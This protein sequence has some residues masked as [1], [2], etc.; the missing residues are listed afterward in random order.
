MG[1]LHFLFISAFLAGGVVL[2]GQT[3]VTGTG[4]VV[5]QNQPFQRPQVCETCHQRQYNELR[6]AVKAG[7]RNAS[8]LQNALELSANFL[9][10]GLLRPVYSDSTILLPDGTPLNTN[11][12]TT[13]LFGEV[14][15][16]QSGFCLTCHNPYTEN[17]LNPREVPQLAGVGTQFQPETIRPLR[18]YHM[19]DAQGNQ[20]L[21]ADF[22][23]APPAGSL[24]SL[25]A[26]GITCDL[27]HNVGGPDLN[28][29]FQHDGF[30]NMS[31]LLNESM[32]KVGPFAFPV[33]PKNGFHM[34]SNDQSKISYLTAG[35]FCNA[36]HDVRV[37]LA[38]QG[39]GDLQAEE[40][41]INPGG[42]GVAYFRLEN[43]STEWQTGAYNST[44]NPFG[45][46]TRCQ[47]CHMSLFPFAGSST[48]QVGDMTVTSPTPAIFPQN[49]A[50]VPATS[51]DQNYPLSLRKVVT[52]YFT[53]VDVPLLA[54]SELQ[55][56]LGSSFP[57]PNGPGVD[58]YG[59]PLSLDARRQALLGA[60]VRLNLDQTDSTAAVGGV[61]TVR[62]AVVAL[63]GHRFP[64]GFSQERT[65]YIQLSVTDDNG[66]LLYQSG[67]VV[68]KPHPETGETRPDGNLND[69]DLEHAHAVVNPGFHAPRAANGSYVAG[70]ATA[71]HTNQIFEPGPDDG[72][73]ARVYFGSNEGLVLFRNELTHIY[74]PGE[75]LGRTDA[76][77][78]EIVATKPHYEET[79]SAAFANSVDNFR[80]LRPLT[81]RTFSYEIQLPT[82]QELAE[83]G[84]SQIQGPLHVHAQ[85]N[86][87]HF[88]PLFLR[89]LART[90][91]PEGPAGHGFNL[92]SEQRLDQMVRNVTGIATADAV[93][94]I[95]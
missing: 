52:H 79:F 40:H 13:P 78:K 20:V 69:E 94:N 49:Y 26:S 45:K 63:T 64:A 58:G 77:G 19:V 39:P 46:V 34:A 27:C 11:M 65:T 88:P 84:I 44:N 80:S 87:E 43:L 4:A 95:Q 36:C 91:G 8:P 33:T 54:T 57:D 47:D 30:A 22:G 12:Y 18:D 92:V 9:N 38:G 42:S 32:E 83:M 53:G 29:S 61:F 68:D 56:H 17:G 70:P 59:I 89:F 31:L 55:A 5:L 1:K 16:V 23:G 41:D 3:P 7:Y 14:R 35:A 71:G 75:S 76:S 73:D 10:G 86:F 60:A 72:P 50:A 67:Y 62:A 74:L 28:R 21:P 15:Q 66:V 48:Y 2:T 85:V 82:R 81:P 90:T 25:G 51:T 6:T 37:P 93:V 24:P